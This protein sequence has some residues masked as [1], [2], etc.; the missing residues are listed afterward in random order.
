MAENRTPDQNSQDQDRWY[1][2]P[3]ASFDDPWNDPVDLR[4]K[5]R[6]Q[7]LRYQWGFAV[8]GFGLIVASLSSVGLLLSFMLDLRQIRMTLLAWEF[9]E[10]TVIV[11]ST[12]IG[13][14][15]L[16]GG[17]PDESWRRRS[18]LLLLMFLVD[19]VLWSLD[20]AATLGLT[21]VKVGHEYFRNAL[22][23]ALGWSEFA[24]IASLASGMA[25]TLGEARAADL[26]RAI[27]SLPSIGASV[28]FA[29]FFLRTDW[30]PP[31][32][33]L[34]ERPLNLEL[35]YIWLG[36]AFLSATILVQV[37]MITLYAGRTCAH[38]SRYSRRATPTATAN[39]SDDASA[40][41]DRSPASECPATPAH[42]RS[43]R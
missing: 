39:A 42:A 17:W 43:I 4:T 37:T 9:Q 2:P 15:L 33:P 29:Y 14:G 28:W 30:R 1:E 3:A 12:V 7:L 11:L 25:V 23:Q 26:G 19:L 8:L 16:W 21:D 34:R 32:W 36:S 41:I 24:L 22:G 40:D 27:R 5:E 31:I 38:R 6:L 20:N 10:Q 18:G 35:F 13:G